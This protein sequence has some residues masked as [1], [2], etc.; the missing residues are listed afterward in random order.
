MDE[1]F[2]ILCHGRGV[3]ENDQICPRCHGTGNEPERPDELL[4]IEVLLMGLEN[5]KTP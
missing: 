1:T 3:D 2:C 4:D 5:E